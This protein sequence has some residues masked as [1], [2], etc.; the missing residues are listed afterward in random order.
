MIVQ[1]SSKPPEPLS[2]GVEVPFISHLGFELRQWHAGSS[3]IT[4]EARAE[5]LNSL[6][7]TH[8]G[9]C[10]TLLDVCMAR[11]ARGENKDVSIVTVEMK[12]TFMRPARGKL[13]GRGTLLHRTESM[14]FTEAS[15]LDSH[16][17]LC[18][19]ATGT[20]RYVRRVPPH[21]PQP[22]KGTP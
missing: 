9:A 17:R 1:C 16:G 6:G 7:V 14:A 10:M 8:G 15:I 18:A 21:S 11:A 13:T 22:T 4:Y 2:W 20:F 19:H 12:T 5:H 3:E